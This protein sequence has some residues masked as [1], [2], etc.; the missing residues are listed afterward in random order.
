MS[1][2]TVSIIIATFNSERTLSLCLKAVKEQIY[3]ENKIEI[4]I[5]DGGSKDATLQIAKKYG[6]KVIRV[7]P[8]KQNAEYNKGIGLKYAKNEIV[9]FLDHDNI[10]PHKEWFKNMIKPFLENGKIVGV[11]PLRFSYDKKMTIL[12]RYFALLGG[13]DPVVYYLGKD[14]HLSWAFDNYNL[15]GLAK[16]VGSYYVVKFSS[17]NI[18][19]L[20]GNG[21]ALR[22]EILL[23]NSKADPENFIHTDVVADLIRNGF[24][25]YGLTKDSITHLTNNRLVPFLLRREY[26]IE[27]YQMEQSKKRR[28]HIYDY[29][30]NNMDLVKFVIITL[31]LVVPIRD[32]IRG[33]LKIKDLAWFIHPFACVLFLGTYGFA[34]VKEGVRHALSK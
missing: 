5:A 32:S 29:E 16:D 17:D 28:Y 25:T 8:K 33:F 15:M 14:S 27:K 12:D 4:I 34:V 21:A 10:L 9:L 13:S 22:R 30:K 23:K 20:G 3:D 2:L 6:A 24:D 1:N 31:T 26:F 19:A 18:P 7:D 11:E